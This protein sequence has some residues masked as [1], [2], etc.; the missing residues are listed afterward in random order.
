MSSISEDLLKDIAGLTID[1]INSKI[2]ED[3]K[4]IDEKTKEDKEKKDENTKQINLDLDSMFEEK[5]LEVLGN[6]REPEDSSVEDIRDIVS[7]NPRS[8]RAS[9]ISNEEVSKAEE[10]ANLAR[11]LSKGFEKFIKKSGAWGYNAKGEFSRK[12]A[13]ALL[14]TKHG[15]YSSIPIACNGARCPY[16]AQCELFIFGGDALV[17][18]GDKCPME[19]A[20]I[21]KKYSDYN[22]MFDLDDSSAVDQSLVEE[23]INLDVMLRRVKMLMSINNNGDMVEES[24]CQVDQEGV[25]HTKKE[26]VRYFDVYHKTLD[27]RN[28]MYDLMMS[29]R[30]S[31]KND[32]ESVATITTIMDGIKNGIIVEKRPDNI[33]KDGSVIIELEENEDEKV[34]DVESTK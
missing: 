12:A 10:E 6:S 20:Y 29:T 8:L 1:D 22:D 30:K 26:V 13:M 11:D 23:I 25:E 17:P 19:T 18:V 32:G 14:S 3:K 5:E 24:F 33:L 4:N 16:R 27:H 7:E 2:E 15:M 9:L 34:E 21:E 31:K 28:K